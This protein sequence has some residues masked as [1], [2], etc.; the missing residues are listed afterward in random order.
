[1]NP[2]TRNLSTRRRFLALCAALPA[3]WAAASAV[4]PLPPPMLLPNDGNVELEFGAIKLESTLPPPP[5]TGFVLLPRVGV[6][7]I[8]ELI[9]DEKSK[10][11]LTPPVLPLAD[12]PAVFVSATFRKT[13]FP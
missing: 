2:R 10:L 1:M 3:P 9:D 8:A 7:F 6:E 5:V 13:E 4:A 12:A 11:R